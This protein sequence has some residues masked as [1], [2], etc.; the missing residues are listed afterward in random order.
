MAGPD[1][2]AKT[3]KDLAAA[4]GDF[5]QYPGPDALAH[6][7]AQYLEDIDARFALLGLKGVAQGHDSPG[8]RAI[9]DT[10]LSKVPV[11]T[12]ADR[13]YYRNAEYRSK[14]ETQNAVN[15]QKRLAIRMAD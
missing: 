2:G 4:K 7:G 10:D 3:P 15:E 8:A 11:L 1:E 13:D 9:I 12:A 14:V 5:P 6:A